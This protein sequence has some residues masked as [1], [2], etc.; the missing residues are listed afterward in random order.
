MQIT[1]SSSS[2]SKPFIIPLKS[3]L[4]AFYDAPIVESDIDHCKE[5]AN[6]EKYF[7]LF[8]K[9]LKKFENEGLGKRIA[10]IDISNLGVDKKIID[11]N[12][13]AEYILVD[14]FLDYEMLKAV[15]PNA[16]ISLICTDENRILESFEKLSSLNINMKFDVVV[17]NPPYD[18]SLHLKI[19]KKTMDFVDFDND[20]EII[21]LHPA[22]WMASIDD[23]KKYVWLNGFIKSF[24]IYDINDYFNIG[25]FS[26]GLITHLAK[27][28]KSISEFNPLMF[29]GSFKGGD[30]KI[31]KKIE[32]VDLALNLFKKVVNNQAFVSIS[33]YEQE[34]DLTVEDDLYY[35]QHNLLVGN[36]GFQPKHIYCNGKSLMNG[37]T[38]FENRGLMN[39]T[40]KQNINA[41]RFSSKDEAENYRQTQF[42][43]FILFLDAISRVDIHVHSNFVP[44]MQDYTK[45]WSDERFYKYFDLSEDE[46]KLIEDTIKE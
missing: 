1:S 30:S 2:F 42:T 28:G 4:K 8:E 32:N 34:Y 17:G 29:R 3:D 26:Q 15:C 27:N 45:P 40:T 6:P 31:H 16:D 14:N 10:L 23:K 7:G 18:K 12:P 13:K 41:V 24:K 37:K 43:S 20:G 38:V 35:V 39:K 36:G 33:K 44:F 21:W 22:R 11:L 5:L 9:H 46:I 19:L 25:L